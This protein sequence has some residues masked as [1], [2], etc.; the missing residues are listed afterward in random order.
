MNTA[1]SLL[2]ILLL[3]YLMTKKNSMPS[4]KALPL[5]ALLLYFL[6]MGYFN[7]EANL[8]NAT[9]V[10]GLL[11]ALVPISIVWGVQSFCLKPWKQPVRWTRSEPG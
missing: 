4:F 10:N 7:V 2:P 5:M 11:T 6:K 3:I 8:I 9:V 1:I